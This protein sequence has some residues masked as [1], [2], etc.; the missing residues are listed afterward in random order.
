MPDPRRISPASPMLRQL[1][2]TRSP[3]ETGYAR[4]TAA[5]CLAAA[6]PR[7]RC[8]T[9]RALPTV[10][11][12]RADARS[13]RWQRHCSDSGQTARQPP[14]VALGEE[15]ADPEEPPDEPDEP[16]LPAPPTSAEPRIAWLPSPGTA[17]AAEQRAGK[18]GG[19]HRDRQGR[20]RDQRQE[21]RAMAC[22]P[23]LPW[24]PFLA[25]ATPCPLSVPCVVI[26][27]AFPDLTIARSER[28][29]SNESTPAPPTS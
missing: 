11:G 18:R 26:A 4:A 16:P 2:A 29:E 19:R 28:Q 17:V 10:A 20:Q 1:D 23:S 22:H 3:D 15:P 9:G 6:I 7:A 12:R 5:G 8:P 13:N 14:T 24:V 25:R 21:N 27:F